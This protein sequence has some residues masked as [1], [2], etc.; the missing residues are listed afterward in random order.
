MR[1]EA[2]KPLQRLT[3]AMAPRP[4]HSCRPWML[5]NSAGSATGVTDTERTRAS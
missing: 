5:N 4:W 3:Q 1:N 2:G